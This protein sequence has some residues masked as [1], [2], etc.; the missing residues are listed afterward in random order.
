MRPLFPYYSSTT[1][2]RNRPSLV[3]SANSIGNNIHFYSLWMFIMYTIIY[4]L[5]NILF[6]LCSICF[7]YVMCPP[8]SQGSHHFSTSKGSMVR[9]KRGLKDSTVSMAVKPGAIAGWYP[10]SWMVY[11]MKKYGEIP[12]RMRTGGTPIS[13]KLHFWRL[14]QLT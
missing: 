5:E 10:N 1:P 11:V 3:V 13:E 14:P 9:G 8:S 7:L 6:F 12:S 4:S 2:I